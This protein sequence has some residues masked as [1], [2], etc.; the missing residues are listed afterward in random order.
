MFQISIRQAEIQSR[1]EWEAAVAEA[2]L[3]IYRRVVNQATFVAASGGVQRAREA[4]GAAGPG[5]AGS[6]VV[7]S[8][9][10]TGRPPILQSSAPI[11]ESE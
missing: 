4:E 1:M 6:E 7:E 5:A 10:E 2:I 11:S 8:F 3:E 9:P